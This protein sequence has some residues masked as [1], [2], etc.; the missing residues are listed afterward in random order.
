MVAVVIGDDEGFAE[1]ALAVA[2]REGFINVFACLVQKG[3]KG[4]SI[5]R[6]LLY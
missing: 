5:G 4:L 3:D 2:I 1:E 6:Y